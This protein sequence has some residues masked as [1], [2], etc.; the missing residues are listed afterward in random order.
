MH[1]LEIINVARFCDAVSRARN[2]TLTVVFDAA[3]S[4]IKEATTEPAS[5]LFV[6]LF[7]LA[8]N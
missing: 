1:V 4:P 8:E 7:R 3:E 6:S 5:H 2:V